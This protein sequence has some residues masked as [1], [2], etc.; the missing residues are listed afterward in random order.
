MQKRMGFLLFL[1]IIVFLFTACQPTPET[2]AVVNKNEGV[3]EE[4][5]EEE[6]KDINIINVP[7]HIKEEIYKR[8]GLY[9]VLIDANVEDLE[10]TKF[11]VLSIVPDDFTQE[12]VNN[13]IKYFFGDSALYAEE[14][15]LTKDI[16]REKI[17]KIKAEM[18]TMG[19]NSDD[20]IAAK[21]I[22]QKLEEQYVTAPETVDRT[23]ITSELKFDSELDCEKLWA[24]VDMGYD[25]LS[26]IEVTNRDY[27]QVISII[28]DKDRYFLNSA[29]LI[30]KNAE[31][32][33]MTKNI[34]KDKA[35]HV[36]KELE[37]GNMVPIKVDTG[38]SEDQ[39]NQ[40]Y[41]VTF[42]RS[43]NDLPVTLMEII[44]YSE[45]MTIL[46]PSD[47]IQIRLDDNSVSALYWEFKGRIVEELTSNVELLTFNN[48]LEIAK[49]QLKNKYAW[50]ETSKFDFNFERIVHVDRIALEYTCTKEK[51][52]PGHYLLVPAWNFYGGN[53]LSFE[54]GQTEEEHG[55]RTD[56]CILSLNAVD[57]SVIG[58]G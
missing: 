23:K 47:K 9:T 32:Q 45:A 38:V 35:L 28:L 53:T 56:I 17:V 1:S 51:N 31:G 4:K 15:L 16:I 52:N 44:D 57:G 34:A 10:Q 25:E 19:E 29:D 30:D 24:F 11:S 43:V 33:Q 12:E 18:H 7:E 58:D 50:I 55:M 48:I 37:I 6:Y 39:A 36:L 54:N 5:I 20:L 41:I 8:E 26:S 14:Y 42:R 27:W 49:Q 2:D 21:A 40:G 22:L 46:W 13:I 3:L